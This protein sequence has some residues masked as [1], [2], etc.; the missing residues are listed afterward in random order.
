MVIGLG[1][2]LDSWADRNVNLLGVCPR[3]GKDSVEVGEIN[4]KIGK[5][6][7]EPA[8][9]RVCGNCGLVFHEHRE[10]QEF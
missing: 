5:T 1:E 10:I 8:S 6:R 4:L 9:V 7:S 3:C 2:L